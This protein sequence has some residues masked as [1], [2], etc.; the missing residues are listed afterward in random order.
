MSIVRRFKFLWREI[1]WMSRRP[2]VLM[3]FFFFW[4]ERLTAAGHVLSVFLLFS[5]FVLWVPGFYLVKFFLFLCCGFLIFPLFT[6][7]LA[8]ETSVS[9]VRVDPVKEGDIAEISAVVYSKKLCHAVKL[10]SFRMHPS[11]KYLPEENWKRVASGQSLEFRT[12]VQ[13]FRRG[14][15]P[16]PYIAA[17]FGDPLGVASISRRAEGEYELLVFPRVMKLREF[18]FLTSGKSGLAFAPYLTSTFQ[19]GLDFIGVREYR[20]GDSL[21][22]L[23]HGAFARYGRPFT[24]E[25]AAERGEGIVL[26][27]DLACADLL[28]KTRV[29]NAVRLCAGIASY[30]A[31]RNL[32]GRFFIGNREIPL[33]NAKII[34][35][36]LSALARAPYPELNKPFPKPSL[37][38]PAA[39]PM[40]PVLSVSVLPLESPL[41]TKQIVVSETAFREDD[42][43]SLVL[44]DERE[45]SL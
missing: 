9:S 19:R 29:E 28:S 25:F 42:I 34:P 16:L 20:E 5:L 7:I 15:F 22:D 2:G 13:T 27:L 14:A 40:T 6:L 31:T 26:L 1:P 45:V 8:K 38:S 32:L 18:R 23:H 4:N 39:R 37:W 3:Y 11:L 41:I 30:L 17:T 36:V 35:T 43:L 44:N 33:E 10:A 24:K 12:Q 21:R